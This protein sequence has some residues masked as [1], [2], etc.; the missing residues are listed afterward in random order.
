M[1]DTFV[2]LTEL[3]KINNQNLADINVSDLLLDAPLLRRLP[4][5]VASNGTKHQYLKETG[6]PVVGFRSVNTGRENSVSADTLVEID[7]KLLDAS[8]TCDVAVARAYYRGVN[9]FIAR[10]AARHLRAA[11]ARFEAQLIYGTQT[12]G[13][14]DGFVGMADVLDGLSDTMVVNAG[15]TGTS[16][17][18]AWLIREGSDDVT[19]VT[20]NDGNITIDESVIQ[21]VEGTAGRFTG[22]HTPILAW[23]GMQVGSAYSFGR[24]CNITSANPLTD[25]LLAQA[26]AKFPAARPPTVI[27]VNRTALYQLQQSRV[28]TNPTGAPAPFPSEAFGIP[29]IVTDHITNTEAALT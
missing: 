12:G 29:I 7:L 5:V 26:I 2:G 9:A 3:V 25:A 17:T 11:M 23:A 24:I 15:G 6:A 14:A 21:A 4:A 27:V 20:G 13:S 16:C 8:F 28:A 18:S 10:E 19:V 1:A 22:Y